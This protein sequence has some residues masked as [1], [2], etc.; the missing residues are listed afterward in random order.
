[1]KPEKSESA[2]SRCSV[3]LRRAAFFPPGLDPVLDRGEGDEHAMVA[4]QGPAGG[5]IGQPVLDDQ[6]DGQVDDPAGVMAA[7]VGQV[8]GVGVEVLAAAAAVVLRAEQDDVAGPA[9]EGI[10]QVVEGAAGDPVAVGAMAAP[11]AGAAAVIAAADADLGLGQVLGSSDADG[12]VGAIFAGSWHGVTPESKVLP[13]DTS[14][15]DE[16]F[17]A[18]ARFPCYRL[19]HC[20]ILVEKRVEVPVR[21]RVWS[22]C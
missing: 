16:V 11:R 7:G 8:G 2:Q 6:P 13:G 22:V 18:A 1:M 5:A 12:R 21:G 10:A 15:A 9:G 3:S 20:P 17:T 14:Y 4:P 19:E